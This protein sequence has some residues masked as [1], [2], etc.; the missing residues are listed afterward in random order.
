MSYS[1]RLFFDVVAEIID[2]RGKT[3]PLSEAGYP[4]IEVKHVLPDRIYPVIRNT[5][6]VDHDIWNNWFRAHLKPGDIIFSTVGS[7][8]RSCI[9]P[10]DQKFCIAQNLLGFRIDHSKADPRYVYYAMNGQDFLNEVHGRTI[11]TVQKSIKIADL[12]TCHIP[13][14]P[15]S[16]QKAIAHILGTLDDKIDLIRKMNET[17]EIL[18]RVVFKSW[19]VDYDPIRA[20]ADGRQSIGMADEISILF[21]DS[22]VDSELG[23]IPKGWR[24]TTLPDAIEVNPSIPLRKGT[25]AKY[26]EMKNMPT[27]YARAIEVYE[28]ASGSGAKFLN[29]DTL[30]ARITPCLEN[31]KTA[32]VDFLQ[33]DEVG[34]GSTEYIVFRPRDPIPKTYAYFLARSQEFRA[35]AISNMTGTSGRQRVPA[36]CFENYKIVV[37]E[38]KVLE[39]FGDFSL[40]LLDYMKSRDE[41]STT[42]S[43][44]RNILLPKLLKGD[45]RINE[46]KEIVEIAT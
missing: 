6:F 19:F 14:P 35:F 1:K 26:L 38:Q 29:G 9:T 2:N 30:L 25:I 32:F 45:I 13:F 12:K 3:P 36:N 15:L 44:I 39:A 4:L 7:I 28:R 18:A 20:K 16:I 40:T 23:K 17:F 46:V 21:P 33:E 5:K 8:A 42:L 24:I 11:E 22:F 31:G 37:P 34:W 10:L 27:D 43:E 41:E